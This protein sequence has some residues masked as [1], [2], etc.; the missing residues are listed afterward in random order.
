M[1]FQNEKETESAFPA[2]VPEKLWTD[3]DGALVEC[4]AEDN[5][6]SLHFYG[7]LSCAFQDNIVKY[8]SV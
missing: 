1:P 3:T 2:G 4:A 8:I 5:R 6:M 7:K